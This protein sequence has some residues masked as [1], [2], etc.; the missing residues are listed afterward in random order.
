M[1]I[2]AHRRL[3]DRIAFAY[4]WFFDRQVEQYK[5]IILDNR[6]VFGEPGESR[7]LDVGCGTGAFT[8]ALELTG[9]SVTGIDLSP[10]MVEAG[11][12]RDLDCRID[13][14][15]TG[16][17]YPDGSFDYVTA[18]YM[19][20]GLAPSLR[21][22]F[23]SEAK[24]LARKRIVLHDYPQ[25]RSFFSSLIERLEGDGYFSFVSQGIDE[26]LEIFPDITVIPVTGKSSWY[27]CEAS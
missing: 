20:H 27:V 9:F 3:F 8:R 26:M 24:R 10:K 14:A 19:A 5:K 23:Y 4:K 1:N 12:S 21:S 15:T 16:L 11:R 7:V 2:S 6:E 18:A 13:D 25:K 22:R 17:A